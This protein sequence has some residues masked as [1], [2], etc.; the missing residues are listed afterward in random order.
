MK[1]LKQAKQL[2]LT[3]SCDEEIRYVTKEDIEYGNFELLHDILIA[4]H[5]SLALATL[6]NVGFFQYILPEIQEGLDLKSY[7][8]FKEIWPHTLS[9]LNQT[10]RKLNLRWAALFHDLGKAQAFEIRDN[11]VTFYQH[12]K[13][14]AKIFNEFTKR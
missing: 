2:A 1:V 13:I 4:P 14:S 7:K 8:A 5:V 11:K 9:V 10:P 6:Q 3:G 12:E